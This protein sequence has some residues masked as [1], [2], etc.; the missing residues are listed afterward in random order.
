MKTL[1]YTYVGRAGEYLKRFH[2][3]SPVQIHKC[4]FC[5]GTGALAMP[6]GP[7]DFSAEECEACQ[8]KGMYLL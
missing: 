8:G 4:G 1:F 3:A 5:D 7:D 2:N 6:D